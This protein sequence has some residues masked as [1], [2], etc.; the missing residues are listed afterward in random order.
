MRPSAYA[1]TAV[2]S[3]AC[4]LSA[5]VMLMEGVPQKGFVLEN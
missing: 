4:T 2:G 5:V 3:V 1:R